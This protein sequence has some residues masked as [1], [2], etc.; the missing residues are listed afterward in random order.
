M[1]G[2]NVPSLEKRN[3]GISCILAAHQ[4]T[5]VDLNKCLK[6]EIEKEQPTKSSI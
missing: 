1:G 6:I 3:I 4:F 2:P 5:K